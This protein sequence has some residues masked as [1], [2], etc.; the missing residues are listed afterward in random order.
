MQHF[1]VSDFTA[2]MTRI[3][4]SQKLLKT[5]PHF[6]L[7]RICLYG[8]PVSHCLLCSV[9]II[10]I[11]MLYLKLFYFISYRKALQQKWNYYIFHYL[12]KAPTPSLST[13]DATLF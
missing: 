6:L 13:P 11:T 5:M 12:V 2:K 1:S 10:G 3:Q 8:S 4:N 7:H 9:F